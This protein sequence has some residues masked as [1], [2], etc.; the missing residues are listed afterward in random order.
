MTREQSVTDNMEEFLAILPPRFRDLLVSHARLD[1]LLEVIIDLGRPVEARFPGSYE[2]LGGDATQ[3]DLAYVVERVGHFDRDNRAGIQRTLH[4]ISCIRNRFGDV[5]GVTCR[6]GRAVFGTIDIIRDIIDTGRSLLLLG[7]PGVGKTTKLREAARV[8]ADELDYRV[9]VV[10]TNNEIA[11]DGDIPHPALGRARRMQVPGDREQCDVMIEGVENHMPQ[12]IIID[13]ISNERDAF[14]ARTIAERGVQLIATAHGNTLENL[15]FNPTLADLVGGIHAVTLSDETA[16]LRG[17]QKTV[18]ERKAAPTFDSVVEIEQV[19]RLVIHH[20]VARSVDDLLLGR[21]VTA[22]VREK[23]AEGRVTRSHRTVELVGSTWGPHRQ[24]Y[25][26]ED[27]DWEPEEELLYEGE[28]EAGPRFASAAAGAVTRIY[29]F[30]A[31]RRKVDKAV[32]ELRVPAVTVNDPREADVILAVAGHHEDQRLP[33]RPGARTVT[34]R[35]NTYGQIHEAL[36]EFLNGGDR[37]ARERYALLEAE[38]AAAHVVREGQ[39]AELAP[40]NAYIRRL[41]HELIARHNL[42]SESVGKEPHRR[43]RVLPL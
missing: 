37:T 6:V 35:S 25:G 12:V 43:L 14:A 1:D 9:M 39:P 18:L 23:D 28:G 22:E 33:H 16:R 31:T 8:L 21:S 19:D 32:R 20:D 34:I 17:S 41:Q 38:Q 27:E 26:G 11:G 29:P 36:R 10:D 24:V 5:V 7:R 3:E 40:Q 13:E 2:A 15:M 4:R 42:R 30:G